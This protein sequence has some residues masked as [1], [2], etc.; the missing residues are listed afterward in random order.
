M[1][2]T[3]KQIQQ[4]ALM[5]GFEVKDISGSEMNEE[6][7]LFSGNFVDSENGESIHGIIACNA[8]YPD[9]MID[10]LHP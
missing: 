8:E 1:V 2:L 7:R 6:Y 5:S 3:R 4:L 9:D 10:I